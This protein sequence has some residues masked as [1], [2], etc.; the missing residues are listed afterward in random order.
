MQDLFVYNYYTS[1]PKKSSYFFIDIGA[2]DGITLSNTY[3]LEMLSNLPKDTPHYQNWSGIL[4]EADS[5]VFPKL[6]QNRQSPTSTKYNVALCDKDEEIEFLQ[7]QG[8]Q[9]L[10]GIM[11]EY[12]KE[13]LERIEREIAEFGGSKKIIKIQG[14]K[15]DSIMANHKDIKEID[16]LSI[17]VEGG[18]MSILESIDFSKYHIHLIGI[19]DNYPQDSGIYEFLSA[20][21]YKEIIRL[22]CDRFFERI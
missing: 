21:G 10:S 14:M 7:I 20:R 11:S 5:N 18:E 3:M 22:G 17:D 15:F 9:M 4:I 6:L 2:N 8:P 19:E 12:N 16:Y 13:H 1:K